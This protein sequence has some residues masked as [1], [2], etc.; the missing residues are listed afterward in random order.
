MT[1]LIT[2]AMKR[3]RPGIRCRAVA[4]LAAAVSAALALATPGD[5]ILL[6][7]EKLG[8]VQALLTGIGATPWN[9]SQ[10]G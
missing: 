4:G 2:A 1:A 6:L 7:Y 5:P 3:A 8:P 9:H 10:A